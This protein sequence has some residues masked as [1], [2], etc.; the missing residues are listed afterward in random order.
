MGTIKVINS[1]VGD[2]F[3]LANTVSKNDIKTIYGVS[4]FAAGGDGEQT[5]TI[6]ALDQLT[7]DF[8]GVGFGT[9]DGR[10]GILRVAAG[11]PGGNGWNV[12]GYTNAYVTELGDNGCYLEL[13]LTISQVSPVGY[14]YMIG[15]AYGDDAT[16]SFSWIDWAFYCQAGNTQ[17][18]ESGTQKCS[19]APCGST[20]QWVADR[21]FRVF[22]VA[23]G[24]VTYRYSDDNWETTDRA[25]SGGTENDPTDGIAGY[26]VYQSGTTCVVPRAS[27]DSNLVGAFTLWTGVPASLV[28]EDLT[29]HGILAGT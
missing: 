18:Y 4:G 8:G 20:T 10:T 3:K 5:E 19:A 17:V 24:T 28:L 21:S 12:S 13:T 14:N 15:L 27:D 29:L 23:D 22:V 11:G 6:S 7:D 2:S 16:S 26:R 9:V 25:A 1:V